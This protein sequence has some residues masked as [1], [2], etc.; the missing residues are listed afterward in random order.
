MVGA[1]D[2][3]SRSRACSSVILCL[4]ANV[5]AA[6]GFD[7]S[8]CSDIR[9]LSYGRAAAGAPNKGPSEVREEP[10]ILV[11][12]SVQGLGGISIT[13]D[14]DRIV[15]TIGIARRVRIAA[16][17]SPHELAVRVSLCGRFSILHR[18]F[19]GLCGSNRHVFR[20]FHREPFAAGSRVRSFEECR[21]RQEKNR[22]SIASTIQKGVGEG[23]IGTHAG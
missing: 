15:H 12:L 16:G 1:A 8:G 20:L 17:L 14:N 7:R 4:L 13:G 5:F 21:S 19:S 6:G 3:S 9:P 11:G 10:L 23:I 22:E 2:S 18:Y